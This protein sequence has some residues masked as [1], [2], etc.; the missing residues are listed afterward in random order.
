MYDGRLLK[1]YNMSDD[2][3]FLSVSNRIH[4]QKKEK[5]NLS[6]S[7]LIALEIPPSFILLLAWYAAIGQQIHEKLQPASYSTEKFF[8]S[9]IINDLCQK[10]HES[11]TFSSDFF[12]NFHPIY[13]FKSWNG[14]YFHFFWN[15]FF[16]IFKIVSP[17][18]SMELSYPVFVSCVAQ[19]KCISRP[20]ILRPYFIFLSSI[21]SLFLDLVRQLSSLRVCGIIMITFCTKALRIFGAGYQ[22][23]I[24]RII[25]MVSWIESDNFMITTDNLDT[26]VGHYVMCLQLSHSI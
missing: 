6:I 3:E 15:V 26:C 24:R 19:K 11:N 12:F 14:Y 1:L 10:I 22:N 20:C 4:Q 2:F 5:K 21:S 23:S 16:F 7:A 13:K 18:Y 25:K 17:W 9:C 8:Y